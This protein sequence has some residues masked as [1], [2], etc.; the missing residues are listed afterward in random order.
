MSGFCIEVNTFFSPCAFH[1]E[2]DRVQ[3]QECTKVLMTFIQIMHISN[4]S[5]SWVWIDELLMGFFLLHQAWEAGEA[6]ETGRKQF[7]LQKLSFWVWIFFVCILFFTQKLFF[8]N[9]TQ[10]VDFACEFTFFPVLL[11]GYKEECWRSWGNV[12]DT[13]HPL[14]PLPCCRYLCEE[15]ESVG[16]SGTASGEDLYI[17]LQLLQISR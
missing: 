11:L 2:Y 10:K 5:S 16:Y 13:V 15:E 14:Q 6:G 1:N 3:I 8:F 17:F 7:C 12:F 4:M 9:F